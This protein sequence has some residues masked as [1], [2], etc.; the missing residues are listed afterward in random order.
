M[1]CHDTW[2]LRRYRCGPDSHKTD[3]WAHCKFGY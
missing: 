2:T 3:K 1:I